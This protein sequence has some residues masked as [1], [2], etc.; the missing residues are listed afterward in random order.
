MGVACSSQAITCMHMAGFL[1]QDSLQLQHASGKAA[2]AVQCK[3]QRVT[4][5]CRSLAIYLG[6]RASSW[7]QVQMLRT[8]GITPCSRA[9]AC[10]AS[11][12]QLNYQSSAP[13]CWVA[14]ANP[15]PYPRPASSL[16]VHCWAA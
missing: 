11:T 13:C 5:R 15:N 3:A 1:L 4:D 8:S 9:V 12:T 6:W 2:L 16:T 14:F 10:L 7:P